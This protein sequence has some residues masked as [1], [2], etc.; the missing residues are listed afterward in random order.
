MLNEHELYERMISC[1]YVHPSELSDDMKEIKENVYP[2]GTSQQFISSLSSEQRRSILSPELLA[3]RWG[4]GLSVAK[5]TLENTT[6][7]GIRNIFLRSERKVRKKAPWLSYPLLKSDFYTDHMLSKIKD[8]HNH[9]CGSVFT[10]GLG[11]DRFYPWRSKGEHPSALKEFIN[12]VGIP[13]TL[14][15]DNA[16]EEVYGESRKICQ[17]YHIRQSPS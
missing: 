16:L 7:T 11:Y 1:V 17:K 6:Q 10:N 9:N 14:I 2:L 8:V 3:K 12:D 5:T 13:K 15:S 4:I